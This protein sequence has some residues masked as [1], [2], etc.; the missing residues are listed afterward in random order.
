[1]FVDNSLEMSL[2]T[3]ELMFS[4]DLLLVRWVDRRMVGG[5]GYV[6]RERSECMY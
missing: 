6:L 4:W 1:M 5:T 2:G 3:K